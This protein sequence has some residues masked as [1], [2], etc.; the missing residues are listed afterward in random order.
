MNHWYGPNTPRTY[1]GKHRLVEECETV[2]IGAV[3]RVSGKKA[4][5][6]AIGRAEPLSLPVH[7][8][9]FDLW[10]VDQPHRLPGIRGRLPSLESGSRRLWLVCPGCRKKAAKLYFFYFAPDSL[11]LSDLLCRDC[12]GLVYL[13]Q[14]CGGN[15]WYK[16]T[17]R[18]L[19]RLLREKRKLLARPFSPRVAARLIDIE[20][21]IRILRQRVARRTP[22]PKQNFPYRPAA[23]QRRPSRNLA[24]LEQFARASVANGGEEGKRHQERQTRSSPQVQQACEKLREQ[25]AKARKSC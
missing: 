2:S 18:P 16:E 21:E 22:R 6:A 8:G 1:P 15:R 5:I 4:L 12:H 7:G 17:A 13:S 24:L 10:F 25:T 3:Q 20:A 14:N 19:K 9:C 11:A 23:R